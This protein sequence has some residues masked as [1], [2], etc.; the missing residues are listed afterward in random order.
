M[1]TDHLPRVSLAFLPTP[2]QE[3]PRLR[4][5]PE[6]PRRLARRSC[7]SSALSFVFGV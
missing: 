1:L 6:H 4:Q 3:L 5:A 7:A 2:L